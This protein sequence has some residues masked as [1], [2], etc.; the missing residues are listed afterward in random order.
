MRVGLGFL[1]LALTLASGQ[2]DAQTPPA[3]WLKLDAG[4]FSILAPPGWE[5]RQ[6]VGVDSYVGEFV[7]GGMTLTFDF[8]G[9]SDGYLRQAKKP[10]YVIAHQSIGGF[11][12]KLVSPR[13]PGHGITAVFFRHVGRSTGLC[14]FGKDFTSAQQKLALEIFETL[15]F[16]GPV[17]RYVLPPPPP[18]AAQNLFQMPE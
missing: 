10:E 8:G 7:G 18:H 11:R 14:L 9:Y 15:R 5:F 1:F 13:T 6:L 16:G 12:A 17:P 4:P 3:T 2:A